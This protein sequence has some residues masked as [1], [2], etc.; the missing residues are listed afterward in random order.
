MVTQKNF[1]SEESDSFSLKKRNKSLEK[2]KCVL[3][4]A[5]QSKNTTETF[6]SGVVSSGFKGILPVN[7]DGKVALQKMAPYT[8]KIPI[9]KTLNIVET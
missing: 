9:K 1:S 4:M 2:F 6:N 8:K 3:R 5:R 7:Q